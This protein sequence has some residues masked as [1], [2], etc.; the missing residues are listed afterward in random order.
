MFTTSML[1]RYNHACT[2]LCL[3]YFNRDLFDPRYGGQGRF[4]PPVLGQYL[5]VGRRL[6]TVVARHDVLT[7]ALE[8]EPLVVER[9][10]MGIP[11]T[12]ADA[13]S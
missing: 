3:E 1:Y 9:T 11:E 5:P 6:V 8:V 4:L 7:L 13:D 12:R 10:T 2:Y